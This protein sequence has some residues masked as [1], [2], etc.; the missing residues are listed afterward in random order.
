MSCFASNATAGGIRALDQVGYFTLSCR[1]SLGNGYSTPCKLPGFE[2]DHV[3]RIC[4]EYIGYRLLP[5]HAL[6]GSSYNWRTVC[7]CIICFFFPK[8]F[9]AHTLRPRV[10][11]IAN[12]SMKRSLSVTWESGHRAYT[13]PASCDWWGVAI[14]CEDQYGRAPGS[15]CRYNIRTVQVL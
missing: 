5:L 11:L 15:G 4:R 13:Y 6:W 2:S 12:H 1:E 3:E 7:H 8:Q 14:T 10:L 9:S